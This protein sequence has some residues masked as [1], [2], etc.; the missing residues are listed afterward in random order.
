[1]IDEEIITRAPAEMQG[2]IRQFL[3]KTVDIGLLWH[4]GKSGNLGVGALTVA[5]MEIIRQVAAAHSITP[6][7]TIFGMRDGDADYVPSRDAETFVMNMKSLLSPGRYA[8]SVKDMDVVFDIGGGDSFAEIYGAKRFMFLWLSKIIATAKK[9]PVVLSPQTIGPFEHPVYR[10]LATAAVRRAEVVVAR[11]EPSYEFLK[12]MV[13]EKKARLSTDVAFALPYTAPDRPA[14]GPTKVGVNVSGLL[15]HEAETGRNHFGLEIDYAAFLRKFLGSV[16][17][18]DDVEVH[19]FSH[20]VAAAKPE[21]DDGKYLARLAEEFP[22]VVV[23]PPF[24]GPSEAKSYIAGMDFV[25]AARMHACIAAYSS[26][27]PVLPVAYSRKF[28]GLFG[29]LGYDFLIPTTGMS[30]DEA[31]EFALTCFLDR[32]AEMKAAMARGMATV[33]GRLDVYREEIARVLKKTAM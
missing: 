8:K 7:F 9:T 3:E 1:M 11:D 27:V 33:E 26:G 21:D 30:T 20:V 25:T 24:K 4:S 2:R 10:R 32:R 6:K 5:N 13:P 17:K 31:A 18:R 15:Y 14:G 22:G 29:T 23:V 19:L 16:T 12:T 28:S